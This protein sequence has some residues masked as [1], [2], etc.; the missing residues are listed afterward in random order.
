MSVP[1]LKRAVA[2]CMGAGAMD[3]GIAQVAAASGHPVK[4]LD[5]RAQATEQAGANIGTPF[6]KLAEKGKMTVKAAANA[7]ERLIAIND[8]SD[9]ASA[10][11]VI[12]AI[13]E[14]PETKQRLYSDLKAVVGVNRLFS[15]NA[16]FIS[17]NAIGAT[18]QHPGRLSG[19][20]VVNPAPLMVL[21]KT[22]SDLATNPVVAKPLFVTVRARGK[23]RSAPSQR[24]PSFSTVSP[25]RMTAKRCACVMKA[26]LTPSPSTP[27]VAKP[28]VSAWRRSS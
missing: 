11:P 20:H 26:G 3:A 14:N 5:I 22:A 24:L 6:A 4:L 16:S 2:G 28:A 23:F 7:G 21:V 13:V 8:L 1:L 19:L 17:V 12:E 15:T 10:T 9:L 25:D 27:A 18:L